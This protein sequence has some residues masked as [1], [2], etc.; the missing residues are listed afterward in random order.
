MKEYVIICIISI[1]CVCI[2]DLLL[3]TKLFTNKKFWIFHLL[4]FLLTFITDNFLAWRPVV[5][6]NENTLLGIRLIFAPIEDY[7]F[8]FSLLTLN[9]ILFEFFKHTSLRAK[10]NGARQSR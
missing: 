4:A 9:L 5:V 7:L 2:L 3:K 10:S 8:G 6:Y 1:A